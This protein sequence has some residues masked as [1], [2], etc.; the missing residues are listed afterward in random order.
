MEKLVVGLTGASG[1][2]Y[3]LRLM[4]QLK[5][6]KVTIHVIPTKTG[7]QVMEYETQ[8]SLEEKIAEWNQE[9][10]ATVILEE[11][12]N[13]FSKVASGSY[14][15]DAMVILPCSMSTLGEIAGGITTNLLTR[16]A[17]VML[18]EKRPLVL[19]P[20]ETPLSSIHLRNMAKLFDAGATIVAA[21][22]GFYNHPKTLEDLVDFMVGKVLDALKIE[23]SIYKRWEGK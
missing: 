11:V 2:I 5:D 3:F 23:N 9:G 14:K 12:G 18:K 7:T 17:D 15:A 16:S 8:A 22:P 6:L 10:K 13:L 21:M 4:E 19:V 20:R 1:S